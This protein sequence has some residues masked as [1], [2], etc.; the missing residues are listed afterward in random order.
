MKTLLYK[1]VFFLWILLTSFLF[2]QHAAGQSCSNNNIGFNSNTATNTLSFC[3]GTT[4]TT[5]NGG[6]PTGNQVYFWQVSTT[7]ASGPYSTVSP[8][9]GDV[10]DWT[11][12]SSYYN[13]AGTYYF[14]R[15]ISGN[16]ACDGNSDVITLT[17]NVVPS[18]VAISGGGIICGNSTTLT[19]SG[20]SGGTIY[21]QGTASGGTSTAI[22]SASQVINTTGVYYFRARSASGCWGTERSASVTFIT[23]PAATGVTICQGG[24]GS[25]TSAFACNSFA[26]AGTS[27]SGTWNA[28]TDPVANRLTSGIAN[29]ATCSFASPVVT[30]NYVVKY[31]QVS[32]TGSYTITMNSQ[33]FYNGMGYIVTGAFVP[34]NC[35]G[36]GTFIIADD[37]S[38][39]GNEPSLNVNLTAGIT[40]TLIST[41]NNATS[42]TYSG[43]F[44]WNVTPPA[45]GQ[46]MLPVPGN[47][48]WYT[49]PSG[50]SSFG[51]G[52][53]INPAGM[54][55]SGLANTNTPGTT[56]FY[57][58]CSANPGCRTATNFVI[59]PNATISLLSGVGTN[60]QGI[61]RNS[62]IT[63][64]SY[65][66]GGGGT[67]ATVTGLP[68]GVSG[69]Y[70]AAVFTISGSPS[71]AGVYN[72]TVTTT[73]TCTQTSATGTITAGTPPTAT[74]TKKMASACHAGNDGTITVTAS[75]GTPPYT[76]SW[77]GPG[78][79]TANT[80]AIAGL[81]LGDYT[82]IVTDAL[83]CSVTIPD[84]TIWK[85]FATVVTNNGGGS[86]SCA[87]TGNIILY[88]SGGVPPY[89][90]SINGIN[91]FASNIF[92]NLAAGSYTGY[93]KDFGG[94]VSTKAN[95]AVVGAAPMVVTTYTR[96][97]SSCANNGSIELY[98]TGGMP[99]YS[100]SMNDVTYQAGNV[101]SN[102][103]GATTYTC[104]VKDSKGCKTSVPGVLVPKAPTVTVT[105]TKINTSTCANTGI[106]ELH[107]GGG[108]PGYTYSLN[109]ITYQAGNLFT[110]LAAG[111]YNGW[112]KDSKGCKN[113]QFGITIGTDPASVIN[114][115]AN[116]MPSG[117]CT[118]SGSI[119][120]FRTGGKG[121]YT[122]SLNNATY[123][124]GNIFTG[125]AT[126]T[127]TGWVKDSKGCKGFKTG[128]VVNTAPAITVTESHT[129]TSTCTNDGTIQLHPSGGVPGYT[130][131][132]NDITYQAA[133]YFSG[134]AAGN[135]TG[136]V[137]DAKACK[138][139]VNITMRLNPIAVT[140]YAATA[141][142][143]SS[144]NGSIQL[145]RSGGTG[146]YTYSL[147]GNT[148]QT[149]N[150]FAN[151]FP[152]TYTGYVKDSRTCVGIL[153]NIVVGPACAAPRV[154]ALNKGTFSSTGDG[155]INDITSVI[156]YPNPSAT[157]FILVLTGD[158]KE[159]ALISVMDILGRKLYETNATAKQ[160]TR[161]GN[162]LKPGIYILQI[163]QGGKKQSIKL[164]KE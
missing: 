145:F 34:G 50:G 51:S 150:L 13:N 85:A 124:S 39:P 47:I 75:G 57:A 54:A 9:P 28:A 97:A 45:G 29:S 19:A 128:I 4:G 106:I 95:I 134:L 63:N 90:Y 55:G 122:Y 111:T 149:S 21:F 36:G 147:D 16:G 52:A 5:I 110:G 114:V 73:G 17:V 30:A 123:Q 131:S 60:A 151:R 48:L 64:I 164:T 153:A 89:T 25:L 71:T 109:N 118:N 72:Y 143:C 155:L 66:I 119:E 41:T 8:N 24:T 84:I 115:T 6:N 27:I 154:A 108:V 31:F 146:S 96:P 65:S 91:Y 148:Y 94:C 107:P 139:S 12:S 136:W 80:A 162:D 70:N 116:A 144:G 163:L 140:A 7:A 82:V 92:N 20:G 87:P 125:L 142:S 112:I 141:S 158:R 104:W 152:G 23:P 79:Y 62:A 100:Y 56:T 67:G 101:F 105:S 61:C 98:R 133:N 58:E 68:T 120:L 59:N 49:V 161:F 127:Y 10:Q 159:K 22:P 44:N 99:P 2:G 135:Y 113:V 69:S 33:G 18:V 26:N 121:P 37:G 102:L 86:G 132:L 81:V 46:I 88:G 78:G 15:V 130:F 76:Y 38:G 11:I 40:Y 77:T 156:A 3:A 93:V 117:G 129:N 126:G 43:S 1:P 160:Q 35:A 74:F 103:A 42:G 14:R 138:V 137:K 157:E 83:S 53:S 32:V